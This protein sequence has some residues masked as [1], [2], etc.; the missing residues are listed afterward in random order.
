MLFFGILKEVFDSQT[1]YLGDGSNND[2]IPFH[3]L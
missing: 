2:F 1:L 3:V